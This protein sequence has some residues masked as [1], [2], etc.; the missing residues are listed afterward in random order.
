MLKLIEQGL[1]Q[2]SVTSVSSENSTIRP[3][4][5]ENKRFKEKG[6]EDWYERKFE[7]DRINLPEWSRDTIRSIIDIWKAQLCFPYINN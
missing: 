2:T 7:R 6:I 1:T 3:K 4:K 5:G